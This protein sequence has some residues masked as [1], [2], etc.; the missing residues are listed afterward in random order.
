MEELN[1]PVF[2]S[3]KI[4]GL[5]RSFYYLFIVCII[6]L[7]IF[8]IYMLPSENSSDE[9]KAAYFVLTT[10]ELDKLLFVIGLLGTPVFFILYRYS[11]IKQQAVLTLL[12]DKIEIDNF[13]TITSFS[14][15][16]ITDIACNDAM[17]RDGFPKAKLTIDFKDKSGDFASVTLIDYSQSDQLME[18]LLNYENI[19]FYVTNFSSNPEA[20]DT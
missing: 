8:G 11:R 15:S 5:T 2:L 12:K 6:I 19:K 7:F 13:K 18:R 4:P 9:M 17:T 1:Y 20:L 10:S 3:L 16:E 14:I